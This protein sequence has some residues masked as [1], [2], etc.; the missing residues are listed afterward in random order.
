MEESDAAMGPTANSV[1]LELKKYIALSNS[2]LV[3]TLSGRIEEIEH[4]VKE[5]DEAIAEL[6]AQVARVESGKGD[7]YKWKREGHKIQYNFN[8]ELLSAIGAALWALESDKLDGAKEELEKAK[9]LCEV[10][11]F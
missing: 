5:K 7:S 6:E 11:L 4:Q 8:A 10:K 3:T 9:Q 2:E 1:L